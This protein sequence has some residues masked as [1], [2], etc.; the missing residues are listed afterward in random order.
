MSNDIPARPTGWQLCALRLL[1]EGDW[2]MGELFA[3]A[4][5]CHPIA[6]APPYRPW[7]YDSGPWATSFREEMYFGNS[8]VSIRL[9][10]GQPSWRPAD[11]VSITP[12]GR[13]ALAYWRDRQGRVA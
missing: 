12:S 4:C 13:K 2:P 1:S 3:H 5:A 6:D 10:G 7:R 8:W 9:G 11:I